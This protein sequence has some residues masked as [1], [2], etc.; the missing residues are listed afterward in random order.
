MKKFLIESFFDLSQFPYPE[1]FEDCEYAWEVLARL[2]EFFNS[3]KLGKIECPI[4]QGVYLIHPEKISI[5]R[6]TVIEP[7]A[8]I[9]GPCLIGQDCEI[10]HGAYIRGSVLVG[11]Q[12][13]IGHN[14]EI[15]SSILLNAVCAGHCNYVGDSVLGNG[16]NL[17]AGA[18]LANLRLDNKNV[19]ITDQLE[20]IPTNL[21]KMGAVIGDGAQLGCNA[22]TNPGTMIGKGAFCYPCVTVNG[23]IPIQAK[24]RSTQK[25]VIQ[26]YVD[27]SCF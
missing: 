22:V 27:R 11:N 20:K 15:K 16:V 25:M 23:Y 3:L 7:G 9:R 26:E 8:L 13:L 1:V 4:P 10:R 18:K 17:G 2:E 24:V 19:Q 21:K 6:G 12:C 14:S 5:G